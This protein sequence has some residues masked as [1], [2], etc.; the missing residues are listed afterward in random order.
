[1]E[2]VDGVLENTQLLPL[3][4]AGVV[5]NL[6]DLAIP[7]WIPIAPPEQV[8]T[9]SASRFPRSVH[10]GA[11]GFEVRRSRTR[12]G[13]K[14]VWPK[15]GRIGINLSCGVYPL[16]RCRNLSLC[17]LLLRPPSRSPF[18]SFLRG[19]C[20]VNAIPGK[21]FNNLSSASTD[22]I[23]SFASRTKPLAGGYVQQRR[24]KAGHVV[25][26]VAV[27]AEKNL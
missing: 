13:H 24:G 14:C 3:S 8:Q 10:V 27:V 26:F 6:G 1:M 16:S 12:A 11:R 15:I 18:L 9:L 5:P 22:D 7:H 17:R 23:S 4:P 21:F 25:F 20:L 2:G 19:V